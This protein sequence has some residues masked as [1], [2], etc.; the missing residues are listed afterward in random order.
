MEKKQLIS[1]VKP[2]IAAALLFGSSG[3]VAWGQ[4]GLSKGSDVCSGSYKA[5]NYHDWTVIDNNYGPGEG[6]VGRATTITPFSTI[7]MGSGR[8]T[9][10]ATQNVVRHE[11]NPT[12]IDSPPINSYSYTCGHLC[13]GSCYQSLSIGAASIA[14][15]NAPVVPDQSGAT[16]APTATYANETHII[17]SGG[18]YGTNVWSLNQLYFANNPWYKIV[19]TG[20]Q[21]SANCFDNRITS[22]SNTYGSSKKGIYYDI[23]KVLGGYVNGRIE[24]AGGSHIRLTGHQT[25]NS[26][27][28]GVGSNMTGAGPTGS[29]AHLVLPSTH[30]SL[31]IDNWFEEASI[32]AHGWTDLG[33]GGGSAANDV[34]GVDAVLGINE[35]YNGKDFKTNSSGGTILIGATM[36]GSSSGQGNITIISPTT[37][38]AGSP[39]GFNSRANSCDT[40]VYTG[41]WIPLSGTGNLGNYGKA[42]LSA[43]EADRA[44]TV[45]A[46]ISQVHQPKWIT[47][48]FRSIIRSETSSTTI[49]SRRCPP[50]RPVT[51]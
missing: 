2:L 39:F 6:Y 8:I 23:S 14:A 43:P 20:H 51:S 21:T 4:T 46:N 1:V 44:I 33:S 28:V 12:I 22:C 15:P 30:Y 26:H 49:R 37:S 27:T 41:T 19:Y 35:G 7:S 9:V 25:V 17:V 16:Q 31:M 32:T 48:R 36:T 45:D 11:S 13:S 3:G 38:A 10:G 18:G 40:T 47:A 50:V 24:V 5:L 34:L 29:D 42:S